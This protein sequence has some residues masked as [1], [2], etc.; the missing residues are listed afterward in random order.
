MTEI[1]QLIRENIKGLKPYS[2]ARDEYTKAT[3]NMV[4][5]DANEN[6]FETGVN[7]YPDPKQNRLKEEL[8]KIKGVSTSNI[9]FGN[10][11][12]EIIDLI[13]R[14]FCE[15]KQDKILV[16]PPTYGMYKVCADIN[17]VEVKPI[18]LTNTFQPDVEAI[19]SQA[20]ANTKLLFLCSPNNPSGNSFNT[21]LIEKLLIEFSGI[22]V[23]DEA[24]I[25]FSEQESWLQRLDEFP[26]LVI[27]QT[28]SKAYGMAGIRLGVCFASEAIIDVLNTIK[29]PYN[30]NELT[31]LKA[32]ECLEDYDVINLQVDQIKKNKSL[33]IDGLQ[34]ISF[35]KT[36]YPTDANFILVKVDD[37]N[38]RYS[39]LLTQGIVVR[40]RTKQPLCNNCLR[41]TIGTEKE[42]IK[43]LNALKS[44]Q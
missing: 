35:I 10:G 12:D 27:T 25:D 6:P 34:E 15:P 20:N 17:A 22:V 13:I 44:I 11:S 18:L 40:N 19:L 28:F 4:F 30:I 21:D 39:Q 14:V 36:I 32:L 16:L 24:Y 1:N 23:L 33:L 5:L 2:S 31:Q 7:R 42:N 29:P 38:M 37:A 26:N 43:L 8:S 9:L 41:F 3:N